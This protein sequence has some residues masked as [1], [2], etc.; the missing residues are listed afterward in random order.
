[1][2]GSLTPAMNE[3]TEASTKSTATSTTRR[4]IGSQ[5]L[6]RRYVRE[7]QVSAKGVKEE[8]PSVFFQGGEM[9]AD[10]GFADL[11]GERRP[12]TRLPSAFF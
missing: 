4:S 11:M 12:G 3:L 7:R 6:T 9:P 8:H 1:M 10:D 2:G 5:S